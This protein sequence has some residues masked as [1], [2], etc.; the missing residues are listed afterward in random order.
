MLAAPRLYVVPSPTHEQ[1]YAFGSEQH[2]QWLT[3]GPDHHLALAA[4]GTNDPYVD[5]VEWREYD[6]FI[7]DF[8]TVRLGPNGRTF[9]YNAP[10]GRLVPVAERHRG[11]LGLEEVTLL[12]GSVLLM[13]SPHGYLS[14]ALVI[15][16]PTGRDTASL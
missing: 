13:K 2:Q 6:D 8:P 12:P 1:T 7:F 9:Y 16:W 14:L 3:R 10:N 15:G 5:R 11:F 4:E